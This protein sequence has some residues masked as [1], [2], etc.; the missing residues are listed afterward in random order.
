MVRVRDVDARFPEARKHFSLLR[1][2]EE[3]QSLAKRDYVRAS[4]KI[5]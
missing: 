2:G 5:V 3:Y 4:W 1:I